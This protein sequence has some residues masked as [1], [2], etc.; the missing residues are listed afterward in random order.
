MRMHAVDARDDVDR[1][2]NDV[3]IY[4]IYAVYICTNYA[5]IISL[6]QLIYVSNYVHGRL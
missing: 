5:Y 2:K 4:I 6:I 1:F 3:R